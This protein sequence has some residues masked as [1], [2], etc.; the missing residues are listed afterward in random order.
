M[1]ISIGQQ[2]HY[3]QIYQKIEGAFLTVEIVLSASLLSL[4]VACVY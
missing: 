3:C 1:T 4:C 2:N